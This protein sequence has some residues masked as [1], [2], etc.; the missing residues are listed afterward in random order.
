MHTC[1]RLYQDQNRWDQVSSG[2]DIFC[3][4]EGR[5]EKLLPNQQSRTQNIFLETILK[6]MSYSNTTMNMRLLQCIWNSGRVQTG[7]YGLAF[8]QS[9]DWL[10]S[11]PQQICYSENF[12]LSSANPIDCTATKLAGR[13]DS[14]AGLLFIVLRSWIPKQVAL[15]FPRLSVRAW[16]SL[17]NV[18]Q[19]CINAC[20][21][22]PLL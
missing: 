16:I 20:V 1:C 12:G 22:Q 3:R 18:K 19:I 9:F 11:V 4:T 10:C 7:E 14:L 17:Q 6:H 21:E 2:P 8:R 5:Q 13:V 15:P